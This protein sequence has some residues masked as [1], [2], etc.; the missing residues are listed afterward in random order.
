MSVVTAVR[1]V[2]AQTGDVVEAGR[3]CSSGPPSAGN[4]E[5]HCTAALL[6]NL[7][8][9]VPRSAVSQMNFLF[10]TARELSSGIQF[11]PFLHHRNRT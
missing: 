11:L 9:A 7:G 10:W 1:S 8:R 4:C 5:A 3:G 2:R 6:G